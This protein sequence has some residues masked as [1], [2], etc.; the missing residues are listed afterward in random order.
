[1]IWPN[2]LFQLGFLLSGACP[3]AHILLSWCQ[4]LFLQLRL[5]CLPPGF[6]KG[7]KG[8]A[9]LFSPLKSRLNILAHSGWLLHPILK[10]TALIFT[11]EVMLSLIATSLC[12]SSWPC[13]QLEG[14][15]SLDQ[16]L[17]LSRKTGEP[18]KS[19]K[20]ACFTG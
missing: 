7:F 1:M 15:M 10:A 14:E 2:L 8:F 5:E 18:W 4:T 9:V 12:S 11:S 20:C 17:K 19:E 3:L 13:N 6:Y 16:K